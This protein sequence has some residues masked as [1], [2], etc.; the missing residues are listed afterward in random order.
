MFKYLLATLNA[1][2]GSIIKTA[3][4][5]SLIN[6]SSSFVSGVSGPEDVKTI[7]MPIIPKIIDE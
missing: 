4:K 6:V 3:V 2:E 1:N 7:Q 5:R